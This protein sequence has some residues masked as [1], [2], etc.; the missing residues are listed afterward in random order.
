MNDFEDSGVWIIKIIVSATIGF[1]IAGF[2][3]ISVLPSWKNSEDRIIRSSY[4]YTY[5]K[6]AVLLDLLSDYRDLDSKIEQLKGVEANKST[7]ES[8]IAQQRAIVKKME[9]EANLIG[10][11]D[12]PRDVLRFL[13]NKKDG[14]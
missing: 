11:E 13:E 2:I 3:W 6:Q 8:M 10:R 9:L 14:F 12:I 7:V 1:V 4:Q 5:T